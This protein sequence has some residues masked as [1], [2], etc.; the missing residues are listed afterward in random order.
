MAV[1]KRQKVRLTCQCGVPYTLNTV[2]DLP[3][4]C[5][6]QRCRAMLYM[7]IIELRDRQRSLRALIE[8]LEGGHDYRQ[9]R[10]LVS[11]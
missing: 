4:R 10:F 8:A 2:A 11:D 5:R 7:S 3:A 9:A 1:S 6:N